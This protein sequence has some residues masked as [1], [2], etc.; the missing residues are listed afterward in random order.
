MSYID[1]TLTGKYPNKYG[2]TPE[3]IKTLKVLDWEALKKHTWFNR[4]M[5]SPCWCHLEGCNLTGKYDDFDEFWIG[6]YED[7][8]TDC[9]FT[10]CEGMCSYIF[11]E[12]YRAADIEHKADMNVQV[13]A[14]RYLNMLVDKGILSKPEN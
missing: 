5:S 9:H 11:K 6:F 13:N 2:F 7:G 3:N 14:I 12:F 4:A 1:F 8:R 10:S